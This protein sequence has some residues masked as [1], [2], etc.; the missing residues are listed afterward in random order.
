MPVMVVGAAS[1]FG[2][3]LVDALVATGGQVRVFL[4]APDPVLADKR[5][6]RAIG[7]LDDVERLEAAC[8]QV[9]TVIHL[10][11]ARSSHRAEDETEALEVTAISA[12]AADVARVVVLVPEPLTGRSGRR[13]SDGLAFLERRG[14]ET[15]LVPAAARAADQDLIEAILAADARTA[16]D[17]HP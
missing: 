12:Q 15:S 16:P 2:Y 6:H 9:H 1:P 5:V 7:A 14:F 3:D 13:I 17:H 8:A 11:G 10:A 4:R